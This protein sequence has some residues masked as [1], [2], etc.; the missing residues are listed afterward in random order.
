MALI[1]ASRQSTG[2]GGGGLTINGWYPDEYTQT[3]NFVSGEVVIPLTEIPVDYRAIDISYNGQQILDYSSWSY[4]SGTNSVTI[5]FADPYVT[6]YDKPPVF[7]LT[8]PY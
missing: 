8:Y 5:L 6:T 7:Q 1:Q 3:T 4:D 2:G